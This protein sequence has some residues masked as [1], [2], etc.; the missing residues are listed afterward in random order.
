M[1]HLVNNERKKEKKK[2]KNKETKKTTNQNQLNKILKS[3]PFAI[4]MTG[5]EIQEINH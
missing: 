1:N 4:Q 3:K 2:Q 5:E